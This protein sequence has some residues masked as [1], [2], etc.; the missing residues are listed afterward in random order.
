M[1]EP[2]E[3]GGTDD[4]VERQPAVRHPAGVVA[5][6][7]AKQQVVAFATEVAAA[8]QCPASEAHEQQGAQ[9]AQCDELPP[10]ADSGTGMV[11]DHSLV[12]LVAGMS[13]ALR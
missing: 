9:E 11:H 10:H 6:G 1:H 3:H 7:Y 13:S 8:G 5:H 2:I 12:V 4:D